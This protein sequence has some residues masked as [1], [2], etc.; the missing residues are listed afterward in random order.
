MQIKVTLRLH[1]TPT[2]VSFIKHSKCWLGCGERRE[3]L[4]A[5]EPVN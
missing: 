5:A 2:R 3:A 1:L 4:A